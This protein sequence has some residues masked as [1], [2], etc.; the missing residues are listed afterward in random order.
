MKAT[1]EEAPTRE[2]VLKFL[3]ESAQYGNLGLFVGAGF[4]KAVVDTDAKSVALGWG[5]L[6]KK[7]SKELEVPLRTLKREG[8]GYPDLASRICEAHAARTRGT[9]SRSLRK[10][11][12]TISSY[13]AWYPSEKKRAQFAAYFEKLAPSWIITTN[14]DQ[15]PRVPPPRCFVLPWP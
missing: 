2:E 12:R 7:A 8:S 6:L 5:E 1:L 9:P 3:F 10:L 11:K 13:T 15:V 4:S 14:Y